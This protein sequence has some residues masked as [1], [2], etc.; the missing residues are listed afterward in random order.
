VQF[1]QH[2]NPGS[3][4]A[5]SKLGH[6]T[7]AL[8]CIIVADDLTG[9]GDA[10]VYF[11]A[12]GYAT[13]VCISAEREEV[14]AAVV[15]VS[16]DS[17]DGEPVEVL[18]LMANV[19]SR[20]P[21]RS[22]ATLFK[23]IDSTLR[24]NVGAEIAAALEVFGCD[25]A[26]VCPAFPALHRVVEAGVL[27]AGRALDFE[28]IDVLTCLATQG[29]E[30]CVYA[31]PG[32]IG[33]AI[34]AGARVVSLDA[35]C[36]EDLDQIA[37]E[38]LALDRRVLCVGSGGFASAIARTLPVLPKADKLQPVSN[39]P[40]LFC[41]GSDHVVTMAQQAALQA[42][43][44]VR[45][46]Q[47]KEATREDIVSALSRRQHVCLRLPRAH[48]SPR[49]VRELIHGVPA[50]ALLLSG[51]DTASLVCAAVGVQHIELYDEV[52]PGI[53]RGSIRGG[54]FDGASVVTKSGAFGDPDALI[55]VADFFSCH[56]N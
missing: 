33:N 6:P 48:F 54:E 50:A 52:V 5:W 29:L 15:A 3:S 20:L 8:D 17:R 44:P 27:R 30:R 4:N 2:V 21:Y 16:T 38:A 39:G 32:E 36:D 28:P 35:V 56:N 42:Q 14:T 49:S 40:V 24:G 26:V 10:A 7:V 51:G 22:A 19:A 41:I 46:V 31:S 18:A 1:V 11:A 9:A 23:K 47:S 37:I 53:P 34:S 12:R 45:M 25:A 43:R 55:Q 13:N